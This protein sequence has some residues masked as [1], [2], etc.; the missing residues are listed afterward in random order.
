MSSTDVQHKLQREIDEAIES[1]DGKIPDYHAIQSLP[2]LDQVTSE[3][4]RLHP[5]VAVITRCCTKDYAFEGTNIKLRVGQEVHINVIGIQRDPK[6]YP[7]PEQ[8][9][10]ERFGKEGKASR[11]P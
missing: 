8:F 4:L 1:N 7:N 11:H 6:Y 3:T 2:Y 5:S 9:D 10:P